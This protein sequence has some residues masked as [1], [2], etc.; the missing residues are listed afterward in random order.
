M[1]IVDSRTILNA[2][3][4][5]VIGVLWVRTD[6]REDGKNELVWEADN[7]AGGD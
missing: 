2:E 1:M 4:G 3:P 7:Y 6:V 5:K